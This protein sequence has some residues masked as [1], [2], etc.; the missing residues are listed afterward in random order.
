MGGVNGLSNI[1]QQAI[2][3]SNETRLVPKSAYTGEPTCSAR[4]CA[5]S[6]G[7]NRKGR[8]ELF[9]LAVTNPVWESIAVT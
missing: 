7:L 5:V 4:I 1:L 6:V 3:P 8:P 9:S 2:W